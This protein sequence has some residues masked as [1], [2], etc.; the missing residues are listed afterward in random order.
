MYNLLFYFLFIDL[1]EREERNID[2]LLHLFMHSLFDSSVFPDQGLNPQP[3]CIRTMLYPTELLGQGLNVQLFK[4]GHIESW[5]LFQL[6]NP[7]EY[8]WPDIYLKC[9]K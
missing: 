9:Y 4:E 3:W 7:L 2:L 8:S 6:Q 1:R 5:G